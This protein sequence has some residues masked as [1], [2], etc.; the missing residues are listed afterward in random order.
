MIRHLPQVPIL[1][2]ATGTQVSMVVQEERQGE[3]VIVIEQMIALIIKVGL[4]NTLMEGVHNVIE[5]L[6]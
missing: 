5:T 2:L 4:V 1:V 3:G 6:V